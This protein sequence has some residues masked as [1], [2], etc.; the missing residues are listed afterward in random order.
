MRIAELDTEL[1]AWKQEL[2]KAEKL[3]RRAR[4]HPLPHRHPVRYIATIE[5]VVKPAEPLM[6][7][8]PDDT[9]RKSRRGSITV[10][11]VSS[12]LAIPFR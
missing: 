1:S 4:Y 10:T 6:W 2:V 11:S 8:V 7:I 5:G 12:R 3:R 9:A